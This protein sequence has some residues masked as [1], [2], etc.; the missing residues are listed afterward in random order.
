MLDSVQ[1]WLTSRSCPWTLV[2]RP[3]GSCLKRQRAGSKVSEPCASRA[4]TPRRGRDV[5]IKEHIHER[6]G[7]YMDRWVVGACGRPSLTGIS[8]L[9]SGI[10]GSSGVAAPRGPLTCV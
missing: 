6:I 4:S 3:S 2:C 7:G 1:S 8:L 5:L 10:P 9:D